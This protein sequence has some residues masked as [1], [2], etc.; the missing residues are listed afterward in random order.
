MTHPY[1]EVNVPM[2]SSTGT[3]GVHIFTGQAE[4]RSAAL[5]I[6]R[7]VY[8][9]AHTAQQ[10][11]TRKTGKRPDGWGV[12]GYRAGWELDWRAASAILWRD[13]WG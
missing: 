2:R 4:S 7:E 10:A 11:G 9:A 12:R 3:S 5:R 8:H 6:A 13:Q 1:Y